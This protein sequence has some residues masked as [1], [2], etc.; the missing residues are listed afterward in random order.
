MPA[1]HRSREH[2][3]LGHTARRLLQPRNIRAAST[4]N[5]TTRYGQ[6]DPTFARSAFPTGHA[7]LSQ[8][9]DRSRRASALLGIPRSALWELARR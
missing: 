1:G 8:R 5:L 7:E 6:L 4:W 9:S 3:S 2:G